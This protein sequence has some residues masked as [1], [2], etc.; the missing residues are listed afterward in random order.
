[1][2]LKS[3]YSTH[4]CNHSLSPDGDFLFRGPDKRIPET[5]VRSAASVFTFNHHET[6]TPK[7][8]GCLLEDIDENQEV[9][10]DLRCTEVML[11]QEMD[12]NRREVDEADIAEDCQ[13]AE[14]NL[15]TILNYS[16]PSSFFIEVK[17]VARIN[18]EGKTWHSRERERAASVKVSSNATEG[19]ST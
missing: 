2:A 17:V 8:E 4:R 6:I 10:P 18:K 13:L 3:G 12:V 1:M 5:K 11:S 15:H 16:R 9:D 19:S 14:E 7:H